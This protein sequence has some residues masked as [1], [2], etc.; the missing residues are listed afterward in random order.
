LSADNGL[1]ILAIPQVLKYLLENSHPLI[2]DDK[3]E[4]VAAMEKPVWLEKVVKKYQ[5]TLVTI[6]GMVSY[7]WLI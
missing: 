4:Q 7:D 6:P 3:L 2:D 5:F 1:E